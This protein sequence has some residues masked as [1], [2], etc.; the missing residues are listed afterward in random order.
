[1]IISVI[2]AMIGLLSLGYFVGYFLW[3]GFNDPFLLFWVAFGVFMIAW[4]VIHY[5]APGHLIQRRIEI[6][7]AI[8]LALFFVA[9]G[10]TLTPMIR[11]AM[12]EPVA[13]ADYVVVLGAH[14]YGEK[15]SQNLHYRVDAAMEYIE[16]NPHTKLVLSGG[17]GTGEKISEAEAMKR[18][19]LKHKVPESQIILE[20]ASTNTDENIQYSMKLMEQAE[21]AKVI[22][23]SNDFHVYRAIQIAKKQGMY[24]VSGIGSKTHPYSSF[25][26][27]LREVFA[28]WKYKCMGQI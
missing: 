16:E 19:F 2:L 7:L 13:D 9:I 1:M 21:S 18:Y 23:V 25:N 14:V 20:E 24:N 5:F 4:G 10:V 17:Q 6:A 26:M 11:C 15:M 12:D 3:A 28:I 27:Y 8:L 22:I